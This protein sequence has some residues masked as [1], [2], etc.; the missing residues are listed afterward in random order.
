MSRPGSEDQAGH[1]D[2]QTPE[3]E[4]LRVRHT[5]LQFFNPL[6]YRNPVLSALVASFLGLYL[7]KYCQVYCAPWW[8]HIYVCVCAC[9]H[10]H[11]YAHA[12]L[13]FKTIRLNNLLSSK[14]K[15]PVDCFFACPCFF[16]YLWAFG[17]NVWKRWKKR[18]FVLVQVGHQNDKWSSR[19][20]PWGC[21]HLNAVHIY[22]EDKADL[23]FVEKTPE[24]FV[25]LKA[26]CQTLCCR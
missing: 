11:T 18:F 8:M 25:E 24:G 3:H 23:Y 10:I 9:V 22:M 14:Q 19:D 15:N 26:V 6:A 5:I 1:K 2:G 4:T 20:S 7:E 13:C 21:G 16:R 17:K 12:V